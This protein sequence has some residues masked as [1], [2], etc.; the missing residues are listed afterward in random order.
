MSRVGLRPQYTETEIHA[1]S[2]D[3]LPGFSAAADVSCLFA[4]I[5][6]PSLWQPGLSLTIVTRLHGRLCVLTGK[7]TAIANKTHVNVASTPTMR[8][9]TQEAQLLLAER[10]LFNLYGIIDPLRPFVSK[11]L[12]PSVARLPNNTD[13]LAAKVCSLL[14]SKLQ[15]GSAIESAQNQEIGRASLARYTVGFS[16]LEDNSRGEPLY[17]P[18]VLLGT[19]VGLD[20]K[21]AEQIPTNT[22]SYSNLGWAPIGQYVHGVATKSLLEVIPTASP[23]DEI[24]VCVKGLCNVTSST[25]LTDSSEVQRHLSE[26]GFLSRF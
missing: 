25:I 16:Y 18:L 3:K 20:T 1:F 23:E 5:D 26:D 24:E 4:S 12:C 10:A 8:L 13:P 17:E 15:L 7:R 9:P 6:A 14:A 21:I 11:S 2:P 22:P 19:V